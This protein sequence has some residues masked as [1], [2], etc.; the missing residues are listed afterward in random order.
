MLFRSPIVPGTELRLVDS[1]GNDVA[2][3][4]VGEIWTRGPAITP[5]Y[6]NRQREDFFSGDW[7]RSGD[8]GRLRP[9]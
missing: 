2:Q 3:G 7:F 4:E 8:C 9:A 1:D 5:G 6:W